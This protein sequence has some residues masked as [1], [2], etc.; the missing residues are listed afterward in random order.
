M[1]IIETDALL[2]REVTLTD[3]EA[4]LNIY[5]PFITDTSITF[6]TEVPSLI[7]FTERIESYKNYYPYLVCEIDN[8]VAGY[9]YASKHRE[10]TVYRFSVDVSIYK[11]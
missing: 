1:S 6:E 2:I 7:E 3:A 10:R 9:A 11:R 4:I 5:T 8:D